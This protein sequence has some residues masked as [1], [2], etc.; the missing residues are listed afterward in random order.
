M[1]AQ[2]KPSLYKRLG[3]AWKIAILIDDFIDRIMTDPR[4]EAN[5]R[6]SEANRHISK[7]GFK[8]I[9]TEMTCWATGGPQTYSGRSMAD[10]HRHLHI[11]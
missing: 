4:L 11:T 9:V 6:V 7:A 2:D 3:G 10:S 1:Q 8:Y 5:P